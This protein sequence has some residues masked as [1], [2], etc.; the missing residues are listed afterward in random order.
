MLLGVQLEGGGEVRERTPAAYLPGESPRNFLFHCE[1]QAAA[2]PGHCE[3]REWVSL[4]GG[5]F[6]GTDGHG[7]GGSPRS[8]GQFCRGSFLVCP[9]LGSRDAVTRGRSGC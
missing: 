7:G 3:G 8:H 9:E 5:H 1:S 6:P 2:S 4:L